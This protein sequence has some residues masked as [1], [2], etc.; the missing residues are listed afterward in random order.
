[1]QELHPYPIRQ[2]F[3]YFSCFQLPI[4]DR[5]RSMNEAFLGTFGAQITIFDRTKSTIA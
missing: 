1:M 5:K 4:L 2:E 3:Y